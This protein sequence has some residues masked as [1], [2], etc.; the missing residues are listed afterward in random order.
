VS[1]SACAKKMTKP[2]VA[3]T[4]TAPETRPTHSHD[5]KGGQVQGHARL[6]VNK[7]L[8]L[9]DKEKKIPRGG[10]KELPPQ[11]VS[12]RVWVSRNRRGRWKNLRQRRGI[13]GRDI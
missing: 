12:G 8:V 7:H 2:G 1:L 6:A 10:D 4:F 11:P 3:R 5:I 9:N 13:V